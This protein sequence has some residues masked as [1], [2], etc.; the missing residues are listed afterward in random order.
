MNGLRSLI[1]LVGVIAIGLFVFKCICKIIKNTF[2]N[3]KK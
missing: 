3:N 2:F 1:V